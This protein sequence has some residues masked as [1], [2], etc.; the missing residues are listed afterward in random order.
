MKGFCS[1][2]DGKTLSGRFCAT[3]CDWLSIQAEMWENGFVGLVKRPG[4]EFL[5]AERELDLSAGLV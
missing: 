2:S 1:D 5:F 4:F 3:F